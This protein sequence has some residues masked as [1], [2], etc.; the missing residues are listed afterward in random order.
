MRELYALPP[1]SAIQ[2]SN[3]TQAVA[4]FNNESFLPAD[5]AMFQNLSHLPSCEPP[6]LVF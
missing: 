4:A 2:R 5:L 1:P 3:N 6:N